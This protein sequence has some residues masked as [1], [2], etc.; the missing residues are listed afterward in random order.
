MK[1]G[2]IFDLDGTLVFTPALHVNAWKKL[3]ESYG[4]DLTEPEL[5]EQAGYK[6]VVFI[7]KVLERRNRNDLVAQ[8]LSD[9]KDLFVIEILKSEP[10]VVFD[11]VEAFLI[12]IGEKGIKLALATS[13]TKK[14]ALLLGKELIHF[15]DFM[16]FAEDVVHGKPDPELFLK[17]AKGIGVAP[18]DCIVFEDAS[19]GVAAAK[20]GGFYCVAKD[21]KL[22]QDLSAAD[23]IIDDYEKD[24]L[25][26]L[27]EEID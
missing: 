18:E 8:K 24:K 9:E 26:T 20:R 6:N 1:K 4:I 14:T 19:T 3:F 10:A 23:L 12:A 16:L 22:G 13:A 15:F 17:A 7:N 27:F 25:M 5:I 2:V 21:N 11:G